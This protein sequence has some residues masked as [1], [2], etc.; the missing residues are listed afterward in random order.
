LLTLLDEVDRSLRPDEPGVADLI[1][2]LNSGYRR[3]A[4]RPVL[5]PTKGGGW[6]VDV[7]QKSH[8]SHS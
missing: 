7:G 5:V 4:T 2:I 1:G 6:A 3:G 8:N